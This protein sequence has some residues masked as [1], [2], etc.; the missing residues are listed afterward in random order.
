MPPMLHLGSEFTA[1]FIPSKTGP[2]QRRL[3][4][5]L[6]RKIHS[7]PYRASH[8]S[9]NSGKDSVPQKQV[10]LRL[11]RFPKFGHV[12][13]PPSFPYVLLL[14][15]VCHRSKHEPILDALFRPF[16]GKYRRFPGK[17]SMSSSVR[18]PKVAKNTHCF[19]M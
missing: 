7:L 14:G 9:Q 13:G 15:G 8:F 19:A 10:F 5:L 6:F 4:A 2:G 12:D 16:S 3:R 17:R 11:Y 18:R 1:L